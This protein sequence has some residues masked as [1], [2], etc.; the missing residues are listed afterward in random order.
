MSNVAEMW[1]NGLIMAEEK[2]IDMEKDKEK[3]FGKDTIKEFK[4]IEFKDVS[5]KYET[6][7]D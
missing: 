2:F 5:F 4:K 1:Q 6:K 7:K 3:D